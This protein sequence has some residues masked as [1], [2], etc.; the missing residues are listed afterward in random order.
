MNSAVN[1]PL[2]SLT[3]FTT[4]SCALP[5]PIHPIG[6]SVAACLA[7][8]AALLLGLVLLFVLKRVF[9]QNRRVNLSQARQNSTLSLP[10]GSVSALGS[11]NSASSQSEKPGFIVGFFG[12]PTVEI[13][14]AL[15]KTEW[16]EYK[17]TSFTYQIHTESRRSKF[18]YPSVI[19]ISRRFNCSVSASLREPDKRPALGE[20]QSVKLTPL[21]PD[22]ALINIA[23]PPY[24]RRFSLPTMNR[25]VTQD[26]ERRRHSS[27][28]SRRSITL[29]PG[30]LSRSKIDSSPGPDT[31]LPLS[32]HI[33]QVPASPATSSI[34]AS[35]PSNLK[36]GRRLSRSIIRPLPPLSFAT[37]SPPNSALRTLQISH[38]YALSQHPRK[39]V[40]TSPLSQS[41]AT[42][43]GPRQQRALSPCLNFMELSAGGQALSPTLTPLPSAPSDPITSVLKPK[44]RVRTRRSPTI[45]PIGPSPLRTMI[46]PESLDSELSCYTQI[47]SK[48][49]KDPEGAKDR[50]VSVVSPYISLGDQAGSGFGLCADFGAGA[51]EN[52]LADKHT[53]KSSVSSRRGSSKFEDDD[54][55]VLLDIIRELVEETSAW[56]QGGIFMSPSFKRLLQESGMP[57]VKG[58]SGGQQGPGMADASRDTVASGECNSAPV[59]FGIDFFRAESFY[60]VGSSTSLVSFLG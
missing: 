15:E 50:P 40:A 25:S 5:I 43:P 58:K 56:D 47:M 34:S 3:F 33:S 24:R 39:N 18:A 46:L 52:V 2:L 32:P 19:D 45:G 11:V 6:P 21:L 35:N 54:P 17:Q 1:I 57:V 36:F 4:T 59:D 31:S 10:V 13:Q 55:E 27:L 44:L 38:P 22:K 7:V 29:A 49:S 9:I 14:C 53:T 16:K 23:T 20:L 37:N 8:L 42:F 28:K 48:N 30:S 51:A 26:T 60:D 41:D 12:S